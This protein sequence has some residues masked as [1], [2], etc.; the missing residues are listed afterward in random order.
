MCIRDSLHLVRVN[1]PQLAPLLHIGIIRPDIHQRG[2]GFPA[3]SH[4]DMFEQLPHLV[5]PVSY[6]HLDVYKRQIQARMTWEEAR[7]YCESRGGHL[8]TVLD[9]EQM[10]TVAALLEQNGIQNAWLGASNLNSSVAVSY[11]HRHAAGAGR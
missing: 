4:R 2:N 11:T 7:A 1:L 3:S 5:E 9:P 10:E 6:T 8:A